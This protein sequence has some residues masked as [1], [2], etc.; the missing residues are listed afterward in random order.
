MNSSSS[1]SSSSSPYSSLLYYITSD[2]SRVLHI[3]QTPASGRLLK[4]QAEQDLTSGLV[5]LASTLP[6]LALL[7]NKVPPNPPPS[8]DLDLGSGSSASVS[9][10][11][12]SS[13]SSLRYSVSFDI[14]PSITTLVAL[15]ST[16]WPRKYRRWQIVG[17]SSLL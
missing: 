14:T 9:S 16:S 2:Y 1:N 4:V 10:I 3:S 7:L 15:S 11:S 12:T 5:G 6:T 17:M 8:S 13:A